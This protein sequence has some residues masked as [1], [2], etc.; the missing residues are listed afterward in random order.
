MDLYGGSPGRWHLR[1]MGKT[2]KDSENLEIL[3]TFITTAS[4]TFVI[5]VQGIPQLL[6]LVLR[7]PMLRLWYTDSVGG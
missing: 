2:P 1:G 6:E 5:M 3:N 4:T 7:P